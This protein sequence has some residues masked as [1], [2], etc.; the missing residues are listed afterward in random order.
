MF[1]AKVGQMIQDHNPKAI[2]NP[3]TRFDNVTAS[4]SQA[5]QCGRGAV[6]SGF[7]QAPASAGL[8]GHAPKLP[9]H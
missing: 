4:V 2:R 9:D 8:L 1:F 7:V 6:C 3:A 5:A